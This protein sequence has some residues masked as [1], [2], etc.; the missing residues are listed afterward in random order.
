M[1]LGSIFMLIALFMVSLCKRYWQFF[2]A[3][4]L[5]LGMGMSCVAIPASGA[6]PRF[7][8]QNRALAS[9]ISVAGS[10]LGGVIWPIV[11]D[12]LFLK[13]SL[14]FGWSIRVIGFM[15]IPL[16]GL[17]ILTVRLPTTTQNEQHED[18]PRS[19]RQE[20]IVD[21]SFLKEPP[22]ILLCVGLT[23][24]SLGFFTP[25]FYTSNYA[26]SQGLSQSLSFY[27]LTAINAGSAFGRIMPGFVA[28]RLGKF[29]ILSCA[30]F[31]AGVVVF[32]WTVA[33]SAAGIFIWATIYGVA[34][35]VSPIIGGLSV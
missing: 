2:L 11:M 7:F 10:S 15:M 35:G 21:R 34:S 22:F 25:F 16:L 3:Q 4:G 19:A 27:T 23:L 18:G 14:G 26:I 6:V 5:L 1:T 28:D 32:C 12:Q 30:A 33:S 17:A 20:V 9:G 29:N 8:V 13:T 24:C 31:A